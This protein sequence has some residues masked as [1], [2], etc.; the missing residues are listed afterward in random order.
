MVSVNRATDTH[1]WTRRNTK[2]GLVSNGR[3]S[4]MPRGEFWHLGEVYNFTIV[5]VSSEPR[6]DEKPVS[7]STTPPPGVDRVNQACVSCPSQTYIILILLDPTHRSIH[8]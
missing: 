5:A 7:R 6:L 1:Y 2:D 8:W 3:E 4:P